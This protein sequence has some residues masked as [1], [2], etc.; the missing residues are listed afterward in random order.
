MEKVVIFIVWW[1]GLGVLSSVGLGTGMHS[2]VLF[3]FPHI[4]KT[5]IAAKECG[6]TDFETSGNMWFSSSDAIFA[7]PESADSPSK[8]ELSPVT[9]LQILLK[10]YPACV[11]WGAGTAIG[12]IPPYALSR[13]ASEAGERLAGMDEIDE[14]G[15]QDAVAGRFD[16]IKRSK[17]W[18]IHF[19]K[20]HGFLGIFLLSSWPNMAFDLCGI[21]CGYFLMPFWTFFGATLLGK[22]G[23]KVLMQAAFFTML[24]HED[25]LERFIGVLQRI[26]PLQLDVA[27]LVHSV[28]EQG[29]AQFHSKKQADA[30]GSI[31]GQ[32]SAVWTVFMGILMTLFAIS[33]INQ[34]AQL[35]AA[36]EDAKRVQ[37]FKGKGD[38]GDGIQREDDSKKQR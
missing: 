24:F 1:V 9:F 29:K 22:A 32:L 23:I 7:C 2:G 15:S 26:V 30:G 3:L 19:L 36:E 13:A 4:M 25:Y 17:I 12:E 20:K 10:V 8:E 16:V 21:C 28:L 34:V 31:L 38:G 6:T 5:C 18:M 14:L 35:C 33:C 27:S 11:L 37:A